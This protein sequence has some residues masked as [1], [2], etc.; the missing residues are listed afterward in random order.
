MRNRFFP[1]KATKERATWTLLSMVLLFSLHIGLQHRN[2]WKF[3][4]AHYIFHAVRHVGFRGI[5]EGGSRISQ[6]AI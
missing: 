4:S 3:A 6:D 1:R 2:V 5:I